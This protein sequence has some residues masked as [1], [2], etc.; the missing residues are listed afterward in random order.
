MSCTCNRRQLEIT[1]NKIKHEKPGGFNNYFQLLQYIYKEYPDLRCHALTLYNN[2][3][4]ITPKSYSSLY[5][6]ESHLEIT[7]EKS[8]PTQDMTIP[9]FKLRLKDQDLLC[10]G[11]FFTFNHA[12]IPSEYCSQSFL[13]GLRLLF[14][15]ETELEVPSDAEVF[16]IGSGLS[17]LSLKEKINIAQPIFM[18]LESVLTGVPSFAFFYTRV[19]P[20]LQ[21]RSTGILNLSPDFAIDVEEGAVGAPILSA[22]NKLLGIVCSLNSVVAIKDLVLTFPE[23]ITVPTGLDLLDERALVSFYPTPCYLNPSSKTAAYYFADEAVNKI[24]NFN[25]L[26]QGS[27]ATST[28]FGIFFVGIQ[29]NLES[30]A[31]L[32]D[33]E[34]L[35]KVQSPKKKHLFHAALFHHGML[36]VIGGS[37]SVVEAFNFQENC[38]KTIPSLDKKRSF[39]SAVS[40]RRFIFVFGGKVDGKCKRTVLRFKDKE[41]IKMGFRL[42]V[43]LASFGIIPRRKDCIIF[44]GT[45]GD[46][47]NLESWSLDLKDGT[48]QKENY[49]SSFSF[50]RF[51]SASYQDEVLLFS[52]CCTMIKYDLEADDL[53]Q[54]IVDE[55]SVEVNYF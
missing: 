3:S 13:S 40:V 31:I 21:K 16:A 9:I 29:N 42:P 4:A 26:I 47:I 8:S 6:H 19:Y 34:K 54:V 53:Y 1:Y 20:S 15:N 11:F 12:I 32:F 33:G 55:E 50:G 44:G 39:I 46:S 2:S 7:I 27:S 17:I 43:P 30:V 5:T 52:N 51:S 25:I 36:F 24:I 37:T 10:T 48:F 35:E 49:S 22:E 18:D 41:W 23:D 14:E 45:N 28:L 38:W